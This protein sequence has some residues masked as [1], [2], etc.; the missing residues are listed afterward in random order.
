MTPSELVREYRNGLGFKVNDVLRPKAGC[1]PWRS[2][3]KDD[4]VVV[5]EQCSLRPWMYDVIGEA[6]DP[7]SPADRFVKLEINGHEWERVGQ[8]DDGGIHCRCGLTLKKC[9]KNFNCPYMDQD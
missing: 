6:V 4:T 2:V 1:D 7:K 9:D 5:L 8:A 3:I